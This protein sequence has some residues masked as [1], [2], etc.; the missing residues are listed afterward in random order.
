MCHGFS[1]PVM[2]VAAADNRQ[3]MVYLWPPYV[4]EQAIIFSSCGFFFLSSFFPR[5]I[6]AVAHWMSIPYFHTWCGISANLECRSEMWCMRL[7]QNTGRK[8]R[9]KFAIWAP[10][11]SF[12]GLY[13]RN[14]ACLD[15]RKKNLLNSNISSTCLHNMANFNSG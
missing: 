7:T 11:H 10:S 3:N 12:V 14:N 6:S 2:P 4:I 15:N 5:L 9:Q 13:L 8:N 1:V